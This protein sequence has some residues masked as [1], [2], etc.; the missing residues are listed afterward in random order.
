M[1]MPCAHLT[2]ASWLIWRAVATRWTCGPL[3]T[4]HCSSSA[5]TSGCMTRRWCWD[6]PRVSG[7]AGAERRG[8][9]GST[10]AGAAC[11]RAAADRPRQSC[12]STLKHPHAPPSHARAPQGG[13]HDAAQLVDFVDAGHDLF[14]AVDGGASEELRSLALDLGVDVDARWVVQGFGEGWAACCAG[15]A[16][17]P[18]AWLRSGQSW[19]APPHSPPSINLPPNTLLPCLLAAA[20]R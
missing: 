4:P 13:A 8:V 10:A 18:A 1:Q 3:T 7:A 16:W 5:G 6:R 2:P 19:A 12:R 17:L 11:C 9:G 20:T 14:L 15:D